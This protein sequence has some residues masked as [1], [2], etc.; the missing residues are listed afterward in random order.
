[1]S[2]SQRLNILVL[3][4]DEETNIQ[5]KSILSDEGYQVSALTDPAGAVEEVF[6]NRYQLVLVDVSPDNPAGMKALRA[7]R[8][9]D[10]DLC[11][12]ATTDFLLLFDASAN[13]L[14]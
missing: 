1:M 12:V 10:S 14:L 2:Q 7:L 13:T 8:A 6:R 11:I 5:I 9:S 4:P 3:D